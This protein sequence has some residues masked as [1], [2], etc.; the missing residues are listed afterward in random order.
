M[1]SCALARLCVSFMSLCDLVCLC[2]S[3]CVFA[4]LCVSLCVFVCLCVCDHDTETGLNRIYRRIETRVTSYCT[5]QGS[6]RSGQC[7]VNATSS[8]Q[9][10]HL[11]AVACSKQGSTNRIRIRIEVRQLGILFTRAAARAVSYPAQGKIL[12]ARNHKREIPLEN[13]AEHPPENSTEFHD[14]F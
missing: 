8:K 1:P 9:W 3:L 12:K 6:F 4:R 11:R 5:V 7:E 14:D 2:V 13:V 10:R